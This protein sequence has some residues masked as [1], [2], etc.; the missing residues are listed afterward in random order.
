MHHTGLPARLV[1][2][3]VKASSVLNLSTHRPVSPLPAISGS[4]GHL[5]LSALYEQTSSVLT[6]DGSRGRLR[7]VSRSVTPPAEA[8]SV[9]V[10]TSAR[11]RRHHSAENPHSTQ[12]S[13]WRR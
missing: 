2:S 5:P 1:S 10:L 11:H 8:R 4:V 7:T 3:V 6:L 13:Q 9:S 12:A